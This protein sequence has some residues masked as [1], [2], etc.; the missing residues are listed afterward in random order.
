MEAEKCKTCNRAY[1]SNCDW[2]QGR[3][4]HHPALFDYKLIA[5]M[6]EYYLRF[7]DWSWLNKLSQKVKEWFKH[8]Q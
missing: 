1:S 3:C 4:P 5:S 6:P 7:L 8:V 2:N